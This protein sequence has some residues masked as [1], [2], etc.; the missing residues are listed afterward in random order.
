MEEKT[1][2]IKIRVNLMNRGEIRLTSEGIKW[3][4]DFHDR[5]YDKEDEF[6]NVIMIPINDL[7]GLHNWAIRFTQITTDETKFFAD[8][9]APSVEDYYK[10]AAIIKHRIIDIE[11]SYYYKG[12]VSIYI[13]MK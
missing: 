6:R 9:Y 4:D 5:V 10:I 1:D 11:F 13:G 12:D 3:D 7:I 2:Y 8:I